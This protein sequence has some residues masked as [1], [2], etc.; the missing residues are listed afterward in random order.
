MIPKMDSKLS[1]ITI[2]VGILLSYLVLGY[3]N[4]L[5]RIDELKNVKE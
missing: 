3:S 1:S 4:Y 2:I 5:I